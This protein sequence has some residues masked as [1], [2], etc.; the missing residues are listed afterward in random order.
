MCVW[1]LL[2]R[3]SRFSYIKYLKHIEFYEVVRVLKAFIRWHKSRLLLSYFFLSITSIFSRSF[4][5]FCSFGGVFFWGHFLHLHFYFAYW[6]IFPDNVRLHVFVWIFSLILH[7]H[8]SC[9]KS[10]L[11]C[12]L[13]GF[14]LFLFLFSTHYLLW[15]RKV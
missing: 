12:V 14:V 5:R 11:V 10:F 1:V 3:I 15:I 13:F 4:F 9:E 2:D 7:E 8:F 6:K